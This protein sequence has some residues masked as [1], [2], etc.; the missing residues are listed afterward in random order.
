MTEHLLPR[1]K[2]E[3]QNIIPQAIEQFI[4]AIEAAG[5]NMHSFMLLRH[6][7]V[8]SEK[9]W[10]THHPDEPHAL[11][12]ISKSFCSTAIGMLVDDGLLSIEEPVLQYFPDHMTPEIES[13]MSSLLIRHLLTMTSGHSED[14]TNLIRNTQDGDWVKA[15]FETP[16]EEAPGSRFVY[17]SGAT[18]LLSA[19]V[20]KVTGQTL[21]DYLRPRLFQP[22]GIENVT[23]ESCPM[24]ISC[25]GWGL[26][27]TTEDIAK[28]GQLYLRKGVWD[29]KRLVSEDWIEKATS[30]HISTAAM[31]GID[32]Q[33]GY[34]YQFWRC[35]FGGFCG[36][37]ANGQFCI[38]MPKQDVV[39]AITS[40]EKRMQALLDIVWE[41]LLPAIE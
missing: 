33:Q 10:P 16:I 12:S 29:G 23:W 5:L 17:N 21:L 35:Q 2:P 20:Q 4:I 13:N 36:R 8:V 3:D 27:L 24:G 6:G 18:Y 32:K 25:G 28:F 41:K 38:I 1:S 40:D 19:I 37:G 11:F 7:Y 26:N 9:W 39:I 30:V 31:D 14:P 22:L 15:F 34:G